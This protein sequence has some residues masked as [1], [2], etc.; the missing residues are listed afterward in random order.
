MREIYF[1][2]QEDSAEV[3]EAVRRV[4]ERIGRI[5]PDAEDILTYIGYLYE[6]QGFQNGYRCAME[7]RCFG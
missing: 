1:E 4:T 5:I 3:K 2:S 6:K 7:R